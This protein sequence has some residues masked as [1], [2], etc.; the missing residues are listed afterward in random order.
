MIF[1]FLFWRTQYVLLNGKGVMSI[2]LLLTKILEFK[3]FVNSFSTDYLSL[4]FSLIKEVSC[5]TLWRYLYLFSL[6]NA[7]SHF[8]AYF[9]F[10]ENKCKR[11]KEVSWKVLWRFLYLFSLWNARSHFLYIFFILLQKHK[12]TKKNL[13][14]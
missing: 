10:L 2:S 7:R 5:R 4:N 1:L 12:K 14:R 11:F 13:T 9:S 8:Y 3:G 6:W